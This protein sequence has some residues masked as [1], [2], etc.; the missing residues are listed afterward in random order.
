MK[1]TQIEH[2]CV[3]QIEK[4]VVMEGWPYLVVMVIVVTSSRQY[5]DDALWCDL[6]Q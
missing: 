4:V 6:H 3:S 1:Y 5:R 2:K